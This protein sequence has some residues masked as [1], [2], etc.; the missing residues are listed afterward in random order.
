MQLSSLAGRRCGW[1]ATDNSYLVNTTFKR[2]SQAAKQRVTCRSDTLFLSL[3]AVACSM[4]P[5]KHVA[6]HVPPD[7][8]PSASTI[9]QLDALLLHKDILMLLRGQ[10]KR[11]WSYFSPLF[12]DTYSAEIDALFD[13]LVFR[14]SIWSHAQS[15]ADR[16][17]RIVYRTVDWDTKTI[18]K[19]SQLR[20]L[21]F[22]LLTIVVPYA[23]RKWSN[24]SRTGYLIENV[25]KSVEWVHRF[26]FL[27]SGVYRS[28]PERFCSLRLMPMRSSPSSSP[29]TS[30]AGTQ[31]AMLERLP[32]YDY[33][34]RIMFVYYAVDFL[35]TIL[36]F[37]RRRI[38]RLIRQFTKSRLGSAETSGSSPRSVVGCAICHRD[39]IPVPTQTA[40]GH[41]F[42]YWCIAYE[43][44]VEQNDVCPLCNSKCTPLIRL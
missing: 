14:F 10:Y 15:Y 35:R 4:P 16:L 39:P 13:A 42:C 22:A 41:M 27:H 2:R 26:W 5:V 34:F 43:M 38:S 36:P 9:A 33:V 24:S 25:Y 21:L 29:P 3:Q 44:S 17:L 30:L 12:V 28:L 1:T 31:A 23:Y 20:F 18:R 40:C 19:P 6:S 8:P 37:C 7:R 11:I 32:N